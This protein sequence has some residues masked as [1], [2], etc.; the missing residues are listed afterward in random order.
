MSDCSFQFKAEDA[1]ADEDNEE[2]LQEQLQKLRLAELEFPKALH[3][4]QL[5]KAIAES[6]QCLSRNRRYPVTKALH[7]EV[8]RR[9][10]Y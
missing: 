4:R 10:Q 5:K 2:A 9:Y 6:Q 1:E 8:H 7:R 3:I